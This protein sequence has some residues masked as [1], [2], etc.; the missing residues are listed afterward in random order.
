MLPPPIANSTGSM[1][2]GTG[3]DHMTNWAHGQLLSSFPGCGWA[4]LPSTQRQHTS[5]LSSG[6]PRAQCPCVWPAAPCKALGLSRLASAGSCT[7]H[8]L[9]GAASDAFRF[10]K[11]S[12]IGHQQAVANAGRGA[13]AIAAGSS[14]VGPSICMSSA[15]DL[16]AFAG[17]SSA[18]TYQYPTSSQLGPAQG[19][20]S[21]HRAGRKST[22]PH[23]VRSVRTSAAAGNQAGARTAQVPPTRKPPKDPVQKTL[24]GH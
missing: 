5:A 24:R 18:A 1:D 15:A 7:A 12:Q 19:C 21:L 6:T 17:A 10:K 8:A 20:F 2:A 22:S 13:L 3:A 14:L 4:S 16:G 23:R 9:L 11:R